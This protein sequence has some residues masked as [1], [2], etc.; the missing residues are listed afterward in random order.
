MHGGKDRT[1]QKKSQLVLDVLRSG[2]G[3]GIC[4]T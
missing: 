4:N 2:Q 1:K 3:P